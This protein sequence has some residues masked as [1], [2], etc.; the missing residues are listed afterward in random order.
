VA[1]RLSDFFT[2]FTKFTLFAYAKCVGG[3]VGDRQYE[4]ADSQRNEEFVCRTAPHKPP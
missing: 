2:K 4:R 1:Q 3:G